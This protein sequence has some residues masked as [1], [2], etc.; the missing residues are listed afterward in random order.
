M[1]YRP[2]FIRKLLF[3][4]EKIPIVICN[5]VGLSI[6]KQRKLQL[7]TDVQF[8]NDNDNNSSFLTKLYHGDL[9]HYDMIDNKNN[10]KTNNHANGRNLIHKHCV[11]IISKIPVFHGY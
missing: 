4:C 11:V 1:C 7:H 2:H 6:R 10:G 8:D 5:I 3:I 9:A